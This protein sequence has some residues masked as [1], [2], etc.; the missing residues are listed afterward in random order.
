METPMFCFEITPGAIFMFCLQVWLTIIVLSNNGNTRDT[1]NR[2]E[3]MLSG[4]QKSLGKRTQ[5]KPTNGDSD[6]RDDGI[7]QQML[8]PTGQK[9]PTGCAAACSSCGSEVG[10]PHSVKAT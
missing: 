3:G 2:I 4:I 7:R 10:S 1:L 6:S 8:Q 9:S 5:T